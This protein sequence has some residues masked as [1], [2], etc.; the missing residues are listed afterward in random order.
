MMEGLRTQLLDCL[1]SIDIQIGEIRKIAK[2]AYCTPEELKDMNGGLMMTPL[3]IAKV[4]IL[5][6]LAKIDGD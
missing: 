6:E 1:D 2:N 3:V 4:Q 5:L